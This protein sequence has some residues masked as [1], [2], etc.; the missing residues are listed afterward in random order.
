MP[1]PA[2][3]RIAPR[4]AAGVEVV[5]VRDI[6]VLG[7]KVLLPQHK[8]GGEPLTLGGLQLPAQVGATWPGTSPLAAT[9]VLCTSPGDWLLVSWEHPAAGLR[10]SIESNGGRQSLVS[11][12][13]SD[14]L[15]HLEV[16]GPAAGEV[17]SKGCG[18]DLHPSSFFAGRCAR[19]RFAHI[20][21]V[22]ECLAPSR[23]ALY[24]SR[25]Y[26]HYLRAWL[27]DAAVE[28]AVALS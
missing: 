9:R 26:F 2:D 28:F 12:D 25:S 13:L 6:T 24:V 5:S 17:L 18:L 1:E 8:R 14:G 22:I 7:L 20:A 23:F 4:D 15:A 16:C 19:T 27:A 10:Q 3:V 21:L 11:V